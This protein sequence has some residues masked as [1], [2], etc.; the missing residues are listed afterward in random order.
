M[1]AL[2][3]FLVLVFNFCEASR[4]IPICTLLRSN[5][6]AASDVYIGVVWK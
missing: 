6:Y 2:S 5:R 4:M 3:A 1:I